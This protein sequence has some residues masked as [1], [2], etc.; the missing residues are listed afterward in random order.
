V[1]TNFDDYWSDGLFRASIE[2]L[3][4]KVVDDKYKASN[5]QVSIVQ[6]YQRLIECQFSIDNTP[7]LVHDTKITVL[8][9]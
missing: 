3:F 7:Y 5:L 9:L 8:G 1:A 2:G 4:L 6:R